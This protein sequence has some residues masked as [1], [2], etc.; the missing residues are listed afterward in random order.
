ML[1]NQTNLPVEIQE[2]RAR[3]FYL[4]KKYTSY[5][6][7][8]QARN[9]YQQFLDAF[10]RQLRNPPKEVL[11]HPYAEYLQKRH[12]S[13]YIHYLNKIVELEN[14]LTLLRAT[15]HKREAY[16]SFCNIDFTDW[17]FDRYA[18]ENIIYE[19][20]FYILLGLGISR[21]TDI[22]DPVN[23]KADP[24]GRK[25]EHTGSIRLI[26]IALAYR[27]ICMQ[28]YLAGKVSEPFA[29]ID[30][31]TIRKSQKWSY[32]TIFFSKEWP[33]L[34]IY[35][36][37]IPICPPFNQNPIGQITTGEEVTVTGIYEPWLPINGKVGCPNYFLDGS[38]ATDY[39]LEGTDEWVD[40][41]WRLIWEDKRYLDGTIP[42]EEKTYIFD[43]ENIGIKDTY[44]YAS[45]PEKLSV[46]AGQICPKTGYWFT[47]AQE[48]SR[49]YFKEGEILPEIK[50]DWGEVYWQLDGEE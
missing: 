39:Q 18:D 46:R 28:S 8:D 29:Y 24:L 35:P 6:F 50:S 25:V 13:E 3:A 1:N 38:R 48:N 17:L 43:I 40:V 10:E 26:L 15:Q 5:T 37:P 36:E 45:S 9:L 21:S 42:E 30:K 11:Q 14:G 41:K 49:Q 20:P 33:P 23:Y 47:V 32:E 4:I 22:L 27:N 31:N 7:L 2:A 16:N 44:C 12:E 34:R 19:D